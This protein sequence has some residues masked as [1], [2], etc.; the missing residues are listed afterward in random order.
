VDRLGESLVARAVWEPARLID[1]GP[2]L[3]SAIQDGSIGGCD[4]VAEWRLYEGEPIVELLLRVHWRAIHRVLK[5]VLP[6][7]L[8]R[9]IDGVMGGA[10]ARDL[11]GRERPLQDFTWLERDN[12]RPIG[13]VCPDVFAFDATADGARLTL[14]R[15]PLMAH[16]DPAPAQG[17]PRATPSDQGVHLFRF[18]F[19]A[20]DGLAPDWLAQRAAMAHRPL[21][22]ADWTKGMAVRGDW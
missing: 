8:D 15:S 2:L 21:I 17:F 6:L 12:G 3:K 1:D 7:A 11:D 18:Q 13:V 10:L 22:A 9:R 5:L 16:H 4:L 14:L 20:F 19:A